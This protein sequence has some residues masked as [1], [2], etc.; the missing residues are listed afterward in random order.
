MVQ[1]IGRPLIEQR[2]RLHRWS[3]FES[4]PGFTSRAW[5][6]RN[7]LG[8][9]LAAAVAAFCAR[10]MAAPG[11]LTNLWRETNA[12]QG[13]LVAATAWVHPLNFR[14]FTLDPGVLA[15]VLAAAPQESA[16]RATVSPAEIVFPMPD[17]SRAR[18]K[19][20]ESPIMPPPLAARFPQLKTFSGQGIDDPSATVRFDV[21]PHGFHAQILSPNGAVF[22]DPYMRGNPVVHVSYYKRDYKRTAEPLQCMAAGGPETVPYIYEARPRVTSGASLRTYRLAVA[23]TGEYTEFQG[24]TVSD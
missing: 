19:F 20:V 4:R 16:V 17:G 8:I 21:T 3:T 5:A 9:W 15:G 23:A 10:T 1:N 13:N 2:S 12:P 24:G 22:V 18:F 6:R 14:T 11:S 7:V